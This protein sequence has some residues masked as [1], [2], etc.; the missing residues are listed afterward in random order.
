MTNVLNPPYSVSPTSTHNPC[1]LDRDGYAVASF[2]SADLAAVV[3]AALNAMGVRPAD[4]RSD[5]DAR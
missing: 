2:E 1:L 5:P 4:H 3:A